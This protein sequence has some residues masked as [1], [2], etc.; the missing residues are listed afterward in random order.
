MRGARRGE[1]AEP[2]DPQA[3][4]AAGLLGD[5][6]LQR[7]E[8]AEVGRDRGV[9]PALQPGV[10]AEVAACERPLDR[11]QPIGAERL[12]GGQVCGATRRSW[13]TST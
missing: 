4:R 7:V 13:L 12:Q 1:P 10:R 6:C 5:G 11:Q 8:A 9:D 3:Q 2:G